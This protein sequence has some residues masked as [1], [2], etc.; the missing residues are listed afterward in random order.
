M[1]FPHPIVNSSAVYYHVN[2]LFVFHLIPS[3][4]FFL[5]SVMMYK[6]Y[7]YFVCILLVYVSCFFLCALREIMKVKT[8]VI[9]MFS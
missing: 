5:T 2:F 1:W 3:H 8:S 4:L 6:M 9:R 7:Q